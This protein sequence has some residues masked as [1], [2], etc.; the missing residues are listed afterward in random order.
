MNTRIRARGRLIG[1][2][3]L[4]L[5]IVGGATT[6]I[7]AAL[8]A[9]PAAQPAAAPTAPATAIGV[10]ATRHVLAGRTVQVHG[11]LNPAQAGRVVLVQVSAGHAWKTVAKPRTGARGRFH[12]S[13]RPA[14]ARHYG[15]RAVLSG[16]N[17]T[18][19]TVKGGVTAY[20]AAEASWYGPGLYGSALACG[21]HLTP[22]VI[23]VANKS[24]PCGSRVQ[25]RYRGHNVTARVVDR[26]PY[27]AG[28]EFDLT[29]ATKQRLGFGST[30]TV[31]ASRAG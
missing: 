14:T 4:G 2:L 25:L 12:A 3:A 13:W 21:G 16:P 15:L 26:G 18:V 5:I 29:A 31:W 23:G 19:H 10:S 7:A 20:R 24:L 17:G 27:V 8:A 22:G 9:A 1:L 30:G 11:A 6:G 28:R